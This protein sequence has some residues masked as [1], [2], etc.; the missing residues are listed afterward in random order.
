VLLWC[1]LPDTLFLLQWQM[2][3]MAEK[4]T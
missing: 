1:V 4:I 3:K 2:V